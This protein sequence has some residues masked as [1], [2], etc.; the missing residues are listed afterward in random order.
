MPRISKHQSATPGAP[1][2]H[3]STPVAKWGGL[4]CNWRQSDAN[5]NS[6]PIPPSCLQDWDFILGRIQEIKLA[7][8]G[9]LEERMLGA[10][11]EDL[12]EADL[13]Q[14]G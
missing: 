5:P 3:C 6:R 8:R 2:Q 12:T 7:E 11:Y 4:S 9:E 14:F 1:C 13:W 10:F